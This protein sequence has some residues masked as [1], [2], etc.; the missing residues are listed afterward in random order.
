[1]NICHTYGITWRHEFDHT[2]SEVVP[3]GKT[4]PIH[5]Q[6]LK[7]RKWILRD[8]VVDE[9]YEYKNLG[10]LKNYVCSFASNVDDNIEKECKKA[11]MI[12]SYDFNY[13]KANS[14]V[15]VKFWRQACLPSLLFATELFTL[16]AGQ[17]IKL[18]H[19]QQ[20]FLKT[21]FC[22]PHFAPNSLLLR[23]SGLNSTEAEIDL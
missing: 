1:M 22:V 9:L 18:E 5:S 13:H 10:V 15:Y 21:I 8:S 23:L 11:S 6:L 16:N 2:K 14:L 3:F 12:F 19:C 20:W 4:K 17:L 7:K